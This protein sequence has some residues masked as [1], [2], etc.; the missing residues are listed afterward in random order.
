MGRT[1][2]LF[3]VFLGILKTAHAQVI[4]DLKPFKTNAQKLDYLSKV[5][6]SLSHAGKVED[7]RAV[8]RFAL[9][10][11][12]PDDLKNLTRFNFFL[13]FTYG[14]TGQGD[15][16]IYYYEKSIVYGR[17]DK[18]PVEIKKALQRL[19]FSY[20]NEKKYSNKANNALKELLAISDTTKD[21]LGK[22]ETFVTI[23]YYY[24][25]NGQYEKQIQYLLKS[26]EI[27]KRL[28]A[29]GQLKDREK[30]VADLMNLAEMYIETDQVELGLKYS[31]E[32]R[33]YIVSYPNYL[34][35]HYKDMADILLIKKNTSLARIYYDSLTAM[36]TEANQSS[37]HRN[38]RMASDLA[39]TD[40]YLKKSQVDSAFIYI[41]RANK[42]AEKWADAYTK[43]QIDY[44]TAEVYLAKKDYAKALP[45]LQASEPVMKD[46]DPQIYVALLQSLARCYAATGQYKQSFEAYEKYAPLRDS[47]YMQA[48]KK[49]I[50]DAEARYQNKE[51]QQEIE[52]KNIQ[53]DDAKKQRI[54]LISGLLLLGFSLA[55]LGVIYRN[56][57]KNAQ[58]LD[59]KNKELANAISELEEANRTKA[60]LFSIISHDLRSPISQ[61]Y[62]FL[63][64]QQLNPKLL[65][66]SQRNELSEKIQT[67]T[68]S[69]LETMEDLLLWSKTQMNQ[70]K[71]DI[72]SVDL[73]Y[74]TDQCLKLLQL[75]IE[76][77][78]IIISN[79]LQ[80]GTIV[81]AD[82]YY[83]QAIVRNL[84]QNAI[85]ASE[86]SGLIKLEIKNDE[87]NP[88][89]SIE[90]AGHAFS[91]KDYLSLLAQ[92]ENE[93][94]LSGLGLR[95]VDELSEKTGLKIEFENPVENHTKASLTFQ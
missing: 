20:V 40:Y 39:F 2:L 54:W 19:L 53:I 14:E 15:S 85:K 11:I 30:V 90:N 56:K 1:A 7:E 93:Q 27:K 64:L 81:K 51:K 10:M 26:I 3:F 87:T 5:C 73:Y 58:I 78:N 72:Q 59:L 23:S 65:N 41:S 68:G 92:K 24:G 67:A 25:M 62:Q 46:S 61:V 83:L 21:E 4:R 89:F 33:K 60:K 88:V 80:P 45:L 52:L 17:K 37:V 31:L 94:G 48:S 36:L 76:A 71:A 74:I 63:K 79:K 18:N 22:V 82:P 9:K 12:K 70:F 47:L 95:L 42:M 50:A 34:A 29:S 35:H 6:D 28:I 38:N 32:A 66:D 44:M 8:A 91:Q 57:R 49:S 16:T 86:E 77:K 69:L 55:L 13:A 84:L 43:P 75:N